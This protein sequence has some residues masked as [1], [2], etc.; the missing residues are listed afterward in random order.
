LC[1]ATRDWAMEAR[2]IGDDPIR[3][4]VSIKPPP[5]SAGRTQSKRMMLE[6]RYEYSKIIELSN[7]H[8]VDFDTN[9]NSVPVE[10]EVHLT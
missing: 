3:S 8:A 10:C 5:E 7:I 9:K 4:T 1:P 2:A 6:L